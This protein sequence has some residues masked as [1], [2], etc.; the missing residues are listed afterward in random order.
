[1]VS[2]RL[3]RSRLHG[4]EL[5]WEGREARPRRS[6]AAPGRFLCRLSGQDTAGNAGLGPGISVHRGRVACPPDLEPLSCL[7]TSP[8]L[9]REGGAVWVE[10]VCLLRR[11]P[12]STG[13][14]EAGDGRTERLSPASGL[15]AGTAWPPWGARGGQG[16]PACHLLFSMYAEVKMVGL[17]SQDE[18]AILQVCPGSP[19]LPGPKD[20]CLAAGGGCSRMEVLL[21]PLLGEPAQPP[22]G[23]GGQFGPCICRRAAPPGSPG[24]MGLARSR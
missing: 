19:G 24:K 11:S 15:W 6:R 14:W 22:P 1:M 10:G 2:L 9:A 18:M 3:T 20:G 16:A 4:A 7:S 8:A 13:L 5:S 17:G 23:D 21:P 12:S